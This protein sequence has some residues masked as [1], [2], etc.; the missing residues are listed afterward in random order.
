MCSASLDEWWTYHHTKTVWP[1]IIFNYNLPP[2]KWSLKWNIILIGVILDPN[3][4]SFLWPLVQ[5]LL[6]LEIGVSAFDAITKVVFL[7]HAYLMI[8]FGD[9]PVVSMVMH[10]KGN[11]AIFPCCMCTIKGVHIPPLQVTT[12]YVPLCCR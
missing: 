9:I 11:N 10:M 6:Q 5:E 2:K 3:F 8:V 12:H 1:I 4:V 7:L